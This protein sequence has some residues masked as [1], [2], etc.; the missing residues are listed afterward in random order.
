ML[1]N[2]N[3]LYRGFPCTMLQNKILL[4]ILQYLLFFFFFFFLDMQTTQWTELLKRMI[5]FL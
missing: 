4:C 5:F 3:V 2:L 1:N